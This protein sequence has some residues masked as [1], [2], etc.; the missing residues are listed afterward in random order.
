MKVEAHIIYLESSEREYGDR[1]SGSSFTSVTEVKEQLANDGVEYISVQP[2]SDFCDEWNNTDDD[3]EGLRG[4][5]ENYMITDIF[6][7]K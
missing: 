2:L 1:I 4:D 7:I 6:I 5:L 3:Y